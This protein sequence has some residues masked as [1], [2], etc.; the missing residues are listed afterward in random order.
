MYL[1]HD[2]VKYLWN[3][4][5]LVMIIRNYAHKLCILSHD[6]VDFEF[7]VHFSYEK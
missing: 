5:L 4:F 7:Y 6:V 1:E 3:E 2:A